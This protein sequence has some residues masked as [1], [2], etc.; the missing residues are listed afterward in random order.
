ME[1]EQIQK[2]I[3]KGKTLSK[4]WDWL[5]GKKTYIGLSLHTILI[6]VSKAIPVV[7]PFKE[8]GH[9][10]IGIITGAGLGHKGLKYIKK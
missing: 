8:I 9:I 4:I 3:E 7:E 10:L 1:K 2:P 6:I 5:N